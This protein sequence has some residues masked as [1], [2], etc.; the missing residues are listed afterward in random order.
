M[1]RQAA[2]ILELAKDCLDQWRRRHNWR[3]RMPNELWEIAAKAAA[4][5][6]VDLTAE[7]LLLDPDRLTQWVRRID[8]KP[9]SPAKLPQ[10]VELPPIAL[11]AAP[12]CTLEIEDAAGKKLRIVLKGA[13][14]EHA[15]E[16]SELLWKGDA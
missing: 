13:A 9:Q 5:H 3:G 4:A 14:T 8:P 16:L 11:G 7:Q 1:R 2:P 10:F 6:G 15:M 12:E